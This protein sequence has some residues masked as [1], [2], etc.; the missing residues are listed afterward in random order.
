[1]YAGQQPFVFDLVLY[2]LLKLRETPPFFL[3]RDDKGK[4]LKNGGPGAGE[5]AQHLRVLTSLTE[6]LDLIPS[7][8]MVDNSSSKGFD[9]L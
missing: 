6:D 2:S 4:L 7:I 8:H 9:T 1:V 3:I 5:V